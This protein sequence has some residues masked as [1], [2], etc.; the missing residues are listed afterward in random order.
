MAEKEDI[1]NENIEAEDFESTE[2][3]NDYGKFRFDE[4]F[5]RDERFLVRMSD[6][7]NVADWHI[8]GIELPEYPY[9]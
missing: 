4:S 2:E 7:F 6:E 3:I 5:L 9:S 8:M 1:F